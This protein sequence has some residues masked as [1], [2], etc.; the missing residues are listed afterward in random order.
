MQ[1]S[2][3]S[4]NRISEFFLRL[5]HLRP[6]NLLR[7]IH[8]FFLFKIVTPADVVISIILGSISGIGIII[9]INIGSSIQDDINTTLVVATVFL[10]LLYINKTTQ[11]SLLSMCSA[12]VELHLEEIRT[13][14]AKDLISIEL[15]TIETLPKNDLISGMTRHYDVVNNGVIPLVSA[16]R[17]APLALL[18]FVYTWY[19]SWVSALIL[20]LTSV[21]CTIF[22]ISRLNAVRKS[23]QLMY[24]SENVLIGLIDD[25]LNG[26]VEMKY[27]DK[28]KNEMSENICSNIKK[29]VQSRLNS[30]NVTIELITF[31]SMVNY[32]YAGCIVF[33]LPMLSLHDFSDRSKIVAL[34][35]FVIGP[36]ANLI[37]GV[38][39][40]ELTRFS[41]KS[42]MNFKEK[43][44]SLATIQNLSCAT[45]ANVNDVINDTFEC[46][47][48][49]ELV[50]SRK[51]FDGNIS[52]TVGPI[53]IS[54]Q[55]G[56][57]I[58]IEGGNGSGKSTFIRLITGLYKQDAGSIIFNNEFVTQENILSY[59]ELFGVILSDYHVFK[60]LYGLAP[61]NIPILNKHL[62]DL[63]IAKCC[64]KEISDELPVD[65]LSTGQRKRL[66][67]A[68]TLTE[69]KPILIFDE[70]AADQDPHF[71]KK[72]YKEILPSLKMAGKAV[73]IVS[74]DDKYFNV[75]DERYHMEDGRLDHILN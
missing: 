42:I 27:S 67:L 22:Y 61:E 52:F 14:I 57:L 26:F 48:A 69:D 44:S 74:H 53:N 55:P 12:A 11:T 73:I 28:K 50:F 21:I 3:S 36:I 18:L 54:L 1:N 38:Q 58:L 62:K 31:S 39:N 46:I 59:R 33:L 32:F 49:R 63:G 6:T 30:S 16:I 65:S 60:K 24:H 72:F 45:K 51:S 34:A 66:A 37:D 5:L 29:S 9:A 64:L 71:K 4:D 40:F 56:K 35:L 70:W 17:S 15:E 19:V 20:L 43:I 7:G 75:A 13:Q 23:L 8:E 25:L 2:F 10:L 47:Q 68:I 41:Y